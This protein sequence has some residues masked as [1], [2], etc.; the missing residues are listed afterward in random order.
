MK[1]IF[2]GIVSLLFSAAVYW[3]SKTVL[4][5]VLATFLIMNLYTVSTKRN[6]M[7]YQEL[8][9]TI[10]RVSHYSITGCLAVIILINY[11]FEINTFLF[12]PLMIT[13]FIM[14]FL[15]IVNTKLFMKYSTE[16]T[17]INYKNEAMKLLGV[18]FLFLIL[19]VLSSDFLSDVLHRNL[20]F[21]NTRII[22]IFLNLVLSIAFSQVIY[23]IFKKKINKTL[24]Y[25]LVIP[26]SFIPYMYYWYLSFLALLNLSKV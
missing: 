6:S 2:I 23:I 16:I 18:Y 9:I 8:A 20:S 1:N 3:L 19:K 10:L 11:V 26:H 13:I 15:M 4:L 22:E 14:N 17:D 25:S 12:I 24:Y 5:A 7:S 21:E